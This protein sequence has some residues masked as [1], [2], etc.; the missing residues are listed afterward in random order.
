MTIRVEGEDDSF[1]AVLLHLYT[2]SA[3]RITHYACPPRT[4]FTHAQNLSLDEAIFRG[5]K[6]PP[7]VDYDVEHMELVHE[8]VDIVN[9]VHT[10]CLNLEDG[11]RAATELNVY[12]DILENFNEEKAKR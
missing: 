5:W 4:L 9:K 2:L 8:C 10:K 11:W 7:N 6:D 12:A 1:S 3:V